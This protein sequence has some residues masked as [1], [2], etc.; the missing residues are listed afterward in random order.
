M[1]DTLDTPM[2]DFTDDTDV[3]MANDSWLSS[4][5]HMDEDGHPHNQHTSLP[6][7]EVDM[8]SYD[9]TTEYEMLDESAQPI[10][11]EPVDAEVVDVSF[12]DSPQPSLMAPASSTNDAQA[13]TLQPGTSWAEK[14]ENVSSLALHALPIAESH[15]LPE[16]TTVNEPLPSSENVSSTASFSPPL[17]QTSFAAV[18]GAVVSRAVS[19]QPSDSHDYTSTTG[20]PP[21]DHIEKTHS[22]ETLPEGF[23]QR[24]EGTGS[25]DVSNHLVD[26]SNGHHPEVDPV[27]E[28]SS[29]VTADE[30]SA[31]DA[32]AP[33]NAY[34]DPPPPIHLSLHIGLA[35]G[36]QPDFVLFN[37]PES[38]SSVSEEPLV[39]L[40]HLPSLYSEPISAVFEAFRSEEYFSHLQELSEA[41]MAINAYELQLVIS[42]VR[43]HFVG[44]FSPC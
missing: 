38:S 24:T 12:H 20:E 10:Q 42:E 4:G 35:E 31:T 2:L 22:T 7:L 32:P 37:L 26:G 1:L 28:Q 14:I 17:P 19:K 39:L 11:H 18:D 21:S 30:D 23:P 13:V 43:D 5:M 33:E 36:D 34:V 27:L 16:Q 3:P 29:S 25:T 9:E 6:L 8:A 15:S 40:Q 44:D 41:E